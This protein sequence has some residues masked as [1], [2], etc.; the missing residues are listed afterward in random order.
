MVKDSVAC[1]EERVN[2]F[3]AV[4]HITLQEG[5]PVEVPSTIR[6]VTY[7]EYDS[8]WKCWT[9]VLFKLRD[10]RVYRSPRH[11]VAFPIRP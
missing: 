1:A 9:D 3:A 10:I 7:H 11:D 6:S 5:I 4:V 8:M 2:R